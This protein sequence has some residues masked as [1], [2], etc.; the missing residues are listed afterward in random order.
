VLRLGVPQFAVF[1]VFVGKQGIVIAVL[2]ES[3]FMEYRD[4]V[5]EAAGGQAV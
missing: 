3:A 2:Y 5:A 4:V 1:T